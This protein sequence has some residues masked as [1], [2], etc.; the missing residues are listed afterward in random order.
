[1]DF[2]DIE[3]LTK[4]ASY[5]PQIPLEDVPYTIERYVSQYGLQLNP[6]FQRGHVWTTEQQIAFVTYLLRG[7]ASGRDIYF[8]H[9]GWMGSFEG[10]FVCVD[11]LQ[12][13]TAI[14]RFLNDEIRVFGKL[15]SEFTGRMPSGNDLTF[16][17]NDLKNRKDVLTWYL[18]MNS[19]GTPHSEE[20]L[21]R[22]RKLAD[23]A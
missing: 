4:T 8:N 23:E 11:G 20:E 13:L 7:G 9:P 10:E 19:G 21:N 5:K 12:R 18:E 3:Q 14:M 15:F 22:V 2:K 17:I 6:D 16:H 1:M